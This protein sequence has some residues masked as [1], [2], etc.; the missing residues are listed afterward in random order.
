[1]K[2]CKSLLGVIR[3][4]V[5]IIQCPLLNNIITIDYF[6]FSSSRYLF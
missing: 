6:I 4:F 1:M 5:L 3:L 2:T